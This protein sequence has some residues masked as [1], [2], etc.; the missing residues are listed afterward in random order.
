MKIELFEPYLVKEKGFFRYLFRALIRHKNAFLISEPRPLP[1]LVKPREH[2]SAWARFDGHLVCFDFSDHVFLYD[3][4]ALKK[5]DVYFKANFHRGITHKALKKYDSKEHEFKILPFVWFAGNL[6]AYRPDSLL[7]RLMF[8][9]S[10]P[11]YDVCNV[12]GIYDNYLSKG[13]KSVIAGDDGLPVDPARYHFWIR[14]HVQQAL[15]DAGVSGYYRLTSRGNRN[16]EDNELIYPNLSERKFMKAM[17]KSRFTMINTLPHALLPWKA[18]ES[19]M[20]GRPLIIERTPLVE[21]PEPFQLKPNV[22]YLEMFPGFGGFDDS[23]DIEDVRSYRI[24][25]RLKLEHIREGAK[26]IAESIKNKD[27]V[28]YMTEKV[29]EYSSTVLSPYFVAEFVCEQVQ[30][31]IH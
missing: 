31:R 14:Y 4:E 27:L 7:N 5:C 10:K 26:K 17:I 22:H 18:S 12:V 20:L 29:Q 23:S 8:F 16:I 3:I 6:E 13:E 15:R 1:R 30:R 25:D 28:S 24:L 9:R 19:L 11:V 21:T 2:S